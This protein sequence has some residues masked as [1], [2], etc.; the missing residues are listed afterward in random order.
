MSN[1]FHQ[2]FVVEQTNLALKDELDFEYK[3]K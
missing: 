3:Q 2:T 1:N